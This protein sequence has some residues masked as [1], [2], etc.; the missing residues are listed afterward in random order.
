MPRPTVDLPKYLIGGVEDYAKRNDI[1]K[2][3]AHAAL[4]L[5]G[6]REVEQPGFIS[7]DDEVEDMEEENNNG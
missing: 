7:V 3:E 2:E 4:L 1:S 5:R 6:L